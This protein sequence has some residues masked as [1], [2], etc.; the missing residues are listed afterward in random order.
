MLRYCS[1]QYFS[2]L[3]YVTDLMLSFCVSDPIDVAHGAGLMKGDIV[4]GQG[5]RTDLD[6]RAD[7][8]PENGNGHTVEKGTGGAD[9]ERGS[10]QEGL[11]L[12]QGKGDETNTLH[13]TNDLLHEIVDPVRNPSPK[14]YPV[15]H[16]VLKRSSHVKVK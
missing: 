1:L 3:L 11:D 6:V 7:P 15:G 4:V 10:M 12:L 5:V 8:D 9:L 2:L 16:R 14:L 13:E